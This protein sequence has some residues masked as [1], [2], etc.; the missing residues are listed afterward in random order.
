MYSHSRLLCV[1]LVVQN[2]ISQDFIDSRVT[3][4]TTKGVF[5][6]TKESVED[7]GRPGRIPPKYYS[8]KGIPYARAPVGDM[9]WK[10]TLMLKITIDLRIKGY[11]FDVEF[12]K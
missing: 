2:V 8:F 4:Q 3:V 5:V 7:G 10:V 6:G 9:R 1:L 11:D 12:Y